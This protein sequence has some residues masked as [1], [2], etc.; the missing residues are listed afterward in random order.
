[1][2]RRNRFLVVI[3]AGALVL[4]SYLIGNITFDPFEPFEQQWL[5]EIK[6]GPEYVMQNTRTI[7]YNELGL[8]QFRMTTT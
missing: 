2:I 3:A 4:F 7:Q 8:E 5:R 6:S 1:M